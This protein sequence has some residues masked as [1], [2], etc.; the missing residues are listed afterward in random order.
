MSKLKHISTHSFPGQQQ[1][2]YIMLLVAIFLL[3]LM[4][5]SAQLFTRIAEDTITSGTLRDST[6]SLMLAE[7][8]MEN[9]RGQFI[10]TLNTVVE[11]PTDDLD[12]NIAGAL[13]NNI[14]NPDT[15]LFP[16]MYYVTAGGGLDQTQP[17]ILQAIADGEAANTTASTMTA[18]SI[19]FAANLRLRMNDLFASPGGTA[20]SPMIFTLNSSGL[21]TAI[22]TT[23]AASWDAVDTT[24]MPEK[25]AAWIEVTQNPTIATDVDLFVQAMGQVGNAKSYVQ[26]YIGT[27]NTVTI[28]GN[29]SALAEAS[30]INRCVGC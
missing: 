20:I 12:R 30:N 27:Y 3:I 23:T 5:G 6:E 4:A 17:G 21:L 24:T 1:S 16:Y 25:A 15:I 14:A 8:A 7:T 10:G 11:T 13:T 18:R 26:R 28:L 9:L 29:I 2:G 22:P 19:T